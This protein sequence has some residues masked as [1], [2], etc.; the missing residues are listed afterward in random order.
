MPTSAS[1][2]NRVPNRGPAA[3][4]ENRS[5]ILEAARRLFAERGFHV[6]L[7]AIAKEAGVGQGVLYRH[8]PHRL[9]LAFAAFEDN[10]AT[11]ETLAGDPSPSTFGRL[12]NLLLEQTVREAAF[13]EMMLEARLARSEY[14][15][16]TRLRVALA[17]ALER[18]QAAGAVTDQLDVSGV[19]LAWRMAFGIVATAPS[20]DE[21][22]TSLEVAFRDAAEGALAVVRG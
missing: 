17:S 1:P 10:L 2:V 6:P 15:G 21:A 8:F 14:D 5:A 12:W 13:V 11:F 22:W 20:P 7:N 4:V 3:A 16:E 9:G 19:L 18:A